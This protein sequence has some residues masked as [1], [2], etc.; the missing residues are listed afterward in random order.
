L[1]IGLKSLPETSQRLDEIAA[2]HRGAGCRLFTI[3]VPG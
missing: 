2:R 1:A 3:E